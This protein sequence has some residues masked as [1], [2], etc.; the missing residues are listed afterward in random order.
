MPSGFEAR[1]THLSAGEIHDMFA[2]RVGR[3]SRL[4]LLTSLSRSRPRDNCGIQKVVSAA[5]QQPSTVGSPVRHDGERRQHRSLPSQPSSRDQV[6]QRA[7]RPCRCRNSSLGVADDDK[8]AEGWRR[9]VG[10]S[11]ALRP[12]PPGADDGKRGSARP[13]QPKA[14]HGTQPFSPTAPGCC[15]LVGRGRE[16]VVRAHVPLRRH[17]GGSF[18]RS[19][20]HGARTTR[21]RRRTCRLAF[22]CSRQHAG[23]YCS[24]APAHVKAERT[25]CPG[26]FPLPPRRGA[27]GRANNS[28]RKTARIRSA[29]SPTAGQIRLGWSLGLGQLGPPWVG[30][31]PLGAVRAAAPCALHRWP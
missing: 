8:A 28:R 30:F 24:V 21:G 31:P 29:S 19:Q 20:G 15:C 16:K 5:R 18:F 7:C 27:R 13:A 2:R 3:A 22:T 6:E 17:S 9:S 12:L 10:W 1:W 26:N 25:R 23:H 4:L 11:S 14:Q